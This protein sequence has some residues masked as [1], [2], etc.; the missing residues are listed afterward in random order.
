MNDKLL[1][2]LQALLARGD[3]ERNDNP[4]EREIAMRQANALMA[5]H[6]IT[7][8]HITDSEREGELGELRKHTFKYKRGT[9]TW[10]H[11][12]INQIAKMN[13]CKVVKTPGHKL[14]H[15]IGR[16]AH[17]KIV[18]AMSEYLINSVRRECKNAYRL[19]WDGTSRSAFATSFG[20]GAAMGIQK[21]VHGIM[22]ERARGNIDG[23]SH[24]HALVAI[25]QFALAQRE[26]SDMMA[27]LF[28]NLK[29]G[30]RTSHQSRAGY[31]AGKQ[32]G[33]SVSL[34]TQIGAGAGRRQIGNGG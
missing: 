4:H 2:K 8:A 10:T 11:S 17:V 12:V 15:V 13:A 18:M 9:R 25:N 23:L 20:N 6:S 29:N 34:N 5:K 14:L 21:Q 16:E 32:Y 31:A 27:D 30:R 19:N 26:T 33:N 7:M 24:E 28:R 3:S 1:K 22:E